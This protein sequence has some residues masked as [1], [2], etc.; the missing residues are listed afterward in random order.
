MN[1]RNG[2]VAFLAAN[3]FEVFDQPI[4]SISEKP[5]FLNSFCYVF[6]LASRATLVRG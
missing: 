5:I 4:S 6:Y 3:S 1:E 2:L